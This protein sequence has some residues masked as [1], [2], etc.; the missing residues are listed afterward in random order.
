M[1][2]SYAGPAS[3]NP[4]ASFDDGTEAASSAA[5]RFQQPVAQPGTGATAWQGWNGS[6]P[7][8]NAVLPGHLEAAAASAMAVPSPEPSPSPK[9]EP[10]M[11]EGVSAD[12]CFALQRADAMLHMPQRI[13]IGSP[14][15]AAARVVCL[16]RAWA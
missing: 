9:A 3:D 6:Q 14:F 8:A 1:L 2:M 13:H 7:A 5:S 4:W 16:L 10:E 12:I 15:R 11:S